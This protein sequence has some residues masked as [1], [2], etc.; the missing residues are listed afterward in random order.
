M[1]PVDSRAPA[2]V[3]IEHSVRRGAG[4]WAV[5]CAWCGEA[6]EAGLDWWLPTCGATAC[7]EATGF[8]WTERHRLRLLGEPPSA[9]HRVRVEALSGL[10][11]GEPPD[12]SGWIIFD[13]GAP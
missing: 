12:M 8:V 5:R 4:E 10:L 13:G 9:E 2:V 6:V 7:R 1:A 11:R 3:R